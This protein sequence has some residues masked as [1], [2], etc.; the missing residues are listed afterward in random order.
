ML[1]N[2]AIVENIS[3]TICQG[4]SYDLAGTLYSTSGSYS[5]TLPSSAGCDSTIN[6]DLLVN[7]AI[8]ENISATICQGSSYDLAGTLYNTSGSYS[9]TL[10]SSSLS[11]P[12]NIV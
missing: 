7:N 12:I 11:D 3:A 6:L 9:A 1:V 8:V 5:A 2:N 4:S 10:T